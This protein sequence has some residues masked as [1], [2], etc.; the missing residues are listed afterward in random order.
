MK[1]VKEFAYGFNIDKELTVYNKIGQKKSSYHNYC[2][3]HSYVYEKYDGSKYTES[4][5]ENFLHYLIRENN[6]SVEK[7][8]ILG[9]CSIPFLAVFFSIVYTLVFS[10][11]N[12]INTYNNSINT[13]VDEKFMQ[14]TGYDAKMI[15]DALE[16]NLYSGMKFYGVGAVFMILI[17]IMFLWIIFD[18]IKSSNLKNELYS[19]YIV[20]IQEIIEKQNKKNVEM[21]YTCD[22]TE[23]S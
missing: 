6:R 4:T 17:V 3:W 8:E 22:G 13:L 5:L 15:Y 2:E 18:K 10:T 1:K 11:V 9:G 7:K 14:Y 23:E 12:V 20:I 16:Q 21:R 19:D